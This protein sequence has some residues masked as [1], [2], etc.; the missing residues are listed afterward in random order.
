M[1]VGEDFEDSFLCRALK[2][3][4]NE[5]DRELS[6]PGWKVE[7]ENTLVMNPGV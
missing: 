7:A 3:R 5:P 6:G 4:Y 1:C 2:Q